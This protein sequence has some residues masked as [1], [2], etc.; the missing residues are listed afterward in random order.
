MISLIKRRLSDTL[1]SGRGALY[2]SRA[3]SGRE[4]AIPHGYL[5][6]GSKMAVS[7]S[8]QSGFKN[9]TNP[10]W[11]GKNRYAGCGKAAIGHIAQNSEARLIGELPR[12]DLHARVARGIVDHQNLVRMGRQSRQRTRQGKGP[13]L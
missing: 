1:A 5:S 3:R 8:R 2:R 4:S 6:A 11:I 9:S 7:A 10:R 13:A 12:T